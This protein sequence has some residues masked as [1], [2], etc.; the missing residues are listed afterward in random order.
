MFVYK[1]LHVLLFNVVAVL[2]DSFDA[3]KHDSLKLTLA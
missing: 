2:L 3:A 1:P